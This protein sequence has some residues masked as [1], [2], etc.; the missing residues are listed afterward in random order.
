MPKRKFPIVVGE[1]YHIFS[2]SIAEYQIFRNPQEYQRMKDLLIYYRQEKPELRFSDF[3]RKENK[4]EPSLVYLPKENVKF[5]LELIAYCLMP[6]H[7]HLIVFQLQEEGISTFMKLVLD[8]YARYFNI[9]T[10][11]KGPLWESRFKSILIKTDEQLL[12]LT[13]Y[14]HLNPSTARLVEEP[15]DWKFSSYSEFLEEDNHGLCN[16]R[17]KLEIEPHSYRN[18]VEERIDY[19]RQLAKI[20]HLILE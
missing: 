6:T 16:F 11:R 2:K 13:R 10:K 7:F 19:Q 18:F 20:K 4:E 5:L 17:K 12:H 1:T 9:K 3:L 8:S 15:S 14:I